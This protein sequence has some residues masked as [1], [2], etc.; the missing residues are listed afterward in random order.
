M[1]LQKIFQEPLMLSIAKTR[2]SSIT[3]GFWLFSLFLPIAARG[4]AQICP[5]A[6]RDSAFVQE[7]FSNDSLHARLD[8]DFN[9]LL[10]K[11]QEVVSPFEAYLESKK[12]ESF[13]WSKYP[14]RLS[15][16][17]I[18]EFKRSGKVKLREFGWPKL[19]DALV[20]RRR[21]LDI[22]K[23]QV[24]EFVK[25]HAPDTT[26]AGNAEL[27]R[28]NKE[29]QRLA[30]A[31]NNELFYIGR[32]LKWD[33]YCRKGPWLLEIRLELH[34]PG[35]T[36]VT[37]STLFHYEIELPDLSEGKIAQIVENYR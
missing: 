25:V 37:E 32:T 24:A 22:L 27:Q 20:R 17:Q 35:E 2:L 18:E 15:E 1:I 12:L 7:H 34:G 33:D 9:E 3:A 23:P 26:Q 19:E 30:D 13:Q 6:Y 5:G 10:A 29:K 28:H 8:R 4:Q 31:I 21:W 36:V 14:W 11:L 16:K